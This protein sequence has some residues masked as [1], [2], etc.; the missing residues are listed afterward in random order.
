M[1][2][3]LLPVLAAIETAS[4]EL[5][6]RVINTQH[7]IRPA[8]I[9]DADKLRSS[10]ND[11]GR[12]QD[13]LL[14][15]PPDQTTNIELSVGVQQPEQNDSERLMLQTDTLSR[16]TE[17]LHPVDSTTRILELQYSRI[18]YSPEFMAEMGSQLDLYLLVKE[19][20]GQTTD[21]VLL[22]LGIFYFLCL[23]IWALAFAGVI[24]SA[25]HSSEAWAFVMSIASY[26]VIV[27]VLANRAASFVVYSAALLRE[28]FH[29]A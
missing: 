23:E 11:I 22:G 2:L 27:G 1:F 12:P 29:K 17:V 9:K 18:V 5:N 15:Q 28:R 3:L 10:A 19:L 20:L 21:K 13:R 26:L 4:G 7:L 16:G 8:D 25:T 24:E 14:S 6:T